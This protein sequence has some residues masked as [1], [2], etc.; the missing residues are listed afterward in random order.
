MEHFIEAVLS[1]V[2]GLG[3]TVV[4]SL[5][6]GYA[7]G[8]GMLATVNPCG[9]A[10]LPAYISLFLGDT[11]DAASGASL[12]SAKLAGR[13]VKGLLVSLAVTLGFV[14]LFGVAGAVISAGG[15]FLVGVMPWAGLTIGGLML[16]LGAWMLLERGHLYFGA[17]SRLSARI[18]P[19]GDSRASSPV[20]AFLGYFLFGIAYGIASLSC[21]LPIF[22]I[23]VGSS[24]TADN[25]IGGLW[26]FLSYSLGMGATLLALTLGTAAFQ[27]AAGK[28]LRR[29]MPYVERASA[30]L[31]VLAGVFVIYYWLSIGGLGKIIGDWF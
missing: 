10:L 6:V 21:T 22:L 18:S 16:G 28:L 27:G 19:R 14:L 11:G 3:G 23:V 8:S 17:A 9:F 20:K 7:F 13:M 4:E 29:A 30:V 24:L 2:A 31:I 1:L 15:R 5:P 12:R 26:Q 25:F